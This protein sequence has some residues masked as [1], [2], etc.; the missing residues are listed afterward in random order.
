MLSISPKQK[1]IPQYHDVFDYEFY[2]IWSHTTKYGFDINWDDSLRKLV[3]GLRKL[4]N[5]KISFSYKYELKNKSYFPKMNFL[6]KQS[7]GVVL[8]ND[9]FKNFAKFTGKHLC[10]SLLNKVDLQL[11]EKETPTQVFSW[12][13]KILRTPI[14]IE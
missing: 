7:P 8:K 11:Y 9:A 1:W 14:F 13:T 2:M 5:K 4:R 12:D 10:R 6:L 3:S